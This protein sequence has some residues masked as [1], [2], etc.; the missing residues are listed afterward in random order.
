MLIKLAILR[1]SP[2]S[3]DS[4][5]KE[6]PNNALLLEATDCGLIEQY[7]RKAVR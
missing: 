6:S 5:V 2:G 7:V 3:L 4:S 1:E